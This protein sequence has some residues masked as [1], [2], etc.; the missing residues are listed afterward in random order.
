M[1]AIT[2]IEPNHSW[3]VRIY[4]LLAA[5]RG[6]LEVSVVEI[7]HNDVLVVEV[8]GSRNARSPR[9]VPNNHA[10]I[11][12][13]LF[14]AGPRER[15][16]IAGLVGQRLYFEILEANQNAGTLGSML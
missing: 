14:A 9:I 10:C 2:Q 4:R 5:R 8:H 13:K 3:L 11:F 6:R 15:R 16:R 12:Q 1:A 7:V